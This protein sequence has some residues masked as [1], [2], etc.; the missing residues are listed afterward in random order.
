MSK[1]EASPVWQTADG[2]ELPL[3]EMPSPHIGAAKAKLRDWLKHES[4]PELRRDLRSWTK[5]FSKE[6]RQR[7]KARMK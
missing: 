7:M 6:L 5:R 3:S 1:P 4:D 2:R